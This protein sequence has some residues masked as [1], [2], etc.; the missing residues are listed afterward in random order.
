MRRKLA[1]HEG[2]TL[3][4]LLAAVVILILLGLILNAGLQMAMTSYR[5]M[6]AQSETELLLSTLA[7]ILADDLRYAEDVA[8]KEGM[9]DS[10]FS[11]SYGEGTRLRLENGKVYADGGGNSGLRVLPDGAYGL[12][13]RYE[14]DAME[15]GYADRVF[16][17]KLSVKEKDGDI[18]AETE[19]AV[20]CLNPEKKESEP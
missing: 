3:V 4:E 7:D 12:N 1:G 11:D 17:L 18:H 20:R 10:Y 5:A 16:T 13:G 19:L 8:A 9:L 15:I 6:I 2:L 14:V